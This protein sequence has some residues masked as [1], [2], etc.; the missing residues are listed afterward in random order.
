MHR[1]PVETPPLTVALAAHAAPI[2][3]YLVPV[4]VVDFLTHEGEVRGDMAASIML[5]WLKE[6]SATKEFLRQW[7]SWPRD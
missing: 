3:Q 6:P 2:A 4:D 5:A 7:R 1:K